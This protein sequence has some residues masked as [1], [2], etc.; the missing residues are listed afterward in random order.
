MLEKFYVGR[1]DRRF[2]P[3]SAARLRGLAA[4]GQFLAGDTV[5]KEGMERPVLAVKVKNLFP[6]AP[7]PVGTDA[8][9]AATEPAGPVLP[10]AEEAPTPPSAGREAV[11]AIPTRPPPEG[12][13]DDAVGPPEHVMER[14]P[15]PPP[16]DPV[17]KRR[18][19]AL[20]GAV[21]LSQDG[22]RVQYRKKCSQC[23]HEDTCRSNMLIGNGVTR[24]H[25]FCTRCRKNRQVEI[26]GVMQ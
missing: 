17:R 20:K 16:P 2:G 19:M 13:A 26:H 10:A 3:F 23:G 4:A 14:Q 11:E 8:P 6:A 5:W 24:T 15:A 18:A 22:V 1:G 25:F 12:P 7:P 21:I 9:A